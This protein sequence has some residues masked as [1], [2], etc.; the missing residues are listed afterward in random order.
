M[1]SLFTKFF[2]S[3]FSLALVTSAFAASGDYKGNFQISEPAQVNGKQI[4]AG[5]YTA[6]WEGTGP[7]VQ[8]SI[9]QGKKVIATTSAQVVD[10]NTAASNS[11]AELT[12]G[13]NGDRTLSTLRFS[14]KKYSLQLGSETAG[15]SS[16]TDST[17]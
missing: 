14:G 7:N 4:P 10:L 1:K 6:K 5:E 8:V 11:E 15:V 3:I 17:N 12:K 16:K 2:L 9:M 13:S